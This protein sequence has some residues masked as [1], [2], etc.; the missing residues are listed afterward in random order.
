VS[1]KNVIITT[2]ALSMHTDTV[3]INTQIVAVTRSLT[4]MSLSHHVAAATHCSLD[5]TLLINLEDVW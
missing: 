4:V 5:M 3:H 1:A 2:K